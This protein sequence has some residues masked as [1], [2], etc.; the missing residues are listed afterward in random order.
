ME[1]SL[2]EKSDY[3]DFYIDSGVETERK[4][5]YKIQKVNAKVAQ[6]HKFKLYLEE[7]QLL[8]DSLMQEYLG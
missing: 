6:K 4:D 7:T 8:M 2:R 5:I 1:G 3:D